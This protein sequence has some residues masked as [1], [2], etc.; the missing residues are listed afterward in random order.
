[1]VK[2]I[3]AMNCPADGGRKYHSH[4]GQCIAILF[5]FTL[6]FRDTVSS[7][8]RSGLAPFTLNSRQTSCL[9]LLSAWITDINLYTCLCFGMSKLFFF[10]EPS[11]AVHICN[12]SVR[13]AEAGGLSQISGQLGP[14]SETLS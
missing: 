5:C 11:L 13:E 12:T 7:T 2:K 10:K 8:L 6:F 1:M 9:C 14:H 3:R 4:S